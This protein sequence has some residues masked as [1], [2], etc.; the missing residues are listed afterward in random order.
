MA[1][2]PQALDTSVIEE[3][4]AAY[5]R[6]SVDQLTARTDADIKRLMTERPA[7]ETPE[8]IRDG[9]RGM[10]VLSIGVKAEHYHDD[11]WRSGVERAV[12]EGR[13]GILRETPDWMEKGAS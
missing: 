4:T 13:I 6:T 8:G 9:L 10:L 5:S 11:G 2:R 12:L 1:R 7:T 3:L